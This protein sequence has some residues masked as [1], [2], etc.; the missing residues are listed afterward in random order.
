MRAQACIE[1]GRLRVRSRRS[2]EW[3]QQFPELADLPPSARQRSL[4]LDCELVCCGVTG[5]PDFARLRGRL[6]RGGSHAARAAAV[7]PATVVERAVLEARE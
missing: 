2:V 3:T 7:A 6:A 1:H 4:L 5:H